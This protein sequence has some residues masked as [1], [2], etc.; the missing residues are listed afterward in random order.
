MANNDTR[1]TNLTALTDAAAYGVELPG[2]NLPTPGAPGLVHIDDINDNE[3]SRQGDIGHFGATDDLTPTL[4]GTL[5]GG[6]GLE[7]RIYA[8]TGFLGTT[9]IDENGNWSFTPDMLEGGSKYTFEVLLKDPL[10]DNILVSQPYTVITTATNGDNGDAASIPEVAG[11]L[12]NVG[13]EQG[14]VF[15]GDTTDDSQPTVFGK[16]DAG[17]VVVI[18]DDGQVIGSTTASDKGNWVFTPET[19]LADG[20]HSITAA[21]VGADG[22]P[23]AQS[24]A[25]DFTVDTAGSADTTPPAAATDLVL[26]D[27]VGPQQGD[28]HNG[29]T[30][31]DAKPTLSGQAEAGATVVVSD[32]GQ[33][34]GSAV[35]GSDGKWS[36]TPETDLKDGS[37]S[38]TTVVEDAAGNKSP[39]SDAI[40]FTVDTG[41]EKPVI[42]SAYDDAGVSTGDVLNHGT[43]DDTTPLLKGTAEAGSIVHISAGGNVAGGDIGS[44]VTDATGHWTFQVP[45]EYALPAANNSNETPIYAVAEDAA[46]N[47][48]PSD[49]FYLNVVPL[50]NGA[51]TTPPAAATDLVLTDDVGP[52]QGDIHNGDTTDDAKPTLSGQAEAGATVVVS[53]GGQLIGSAVAGSDGKWN[54]TPETDLKDGSHSFTTVVEDAAGNKSPASDAIGFT[55]DTGIEKPVITSAYDDAGVNTGDVLN[56]GTT[57]D[58]TPLLKG[59]AEAGSI[60]SIFVGGNIAG[61]AIGSALTDATGHWTFQVPDD[62]ALP[63]VNNSNETPIFAV[64]EDA[65]GNAAVSDS[66]NLNVVASDG[67]STSGLTTVTVSD[68]LQFYIDDDSKLKT[69]DGDG[70]TITTN[71]QQ[72]TNHPA[73]GS[74][75]S[76]LNIQNSF[77]DQTTYMQLDFEQSAKDVHFRLSGLE[78]NAGGARIVITDSEGNVIYDQSEKADGDSSV[79][80]G[81]YSSF[82]FIAPEG[83]TIGN[84]RI[85]GDNTDG[86]KINNKNGI[87]GL[88]I[89]QLQY[90][91]DR[92]YNAETDPASHH[93]H[94]V[95]EALLYN[96][97]NNSYSGEN[98]T[99]T[100]NTTMKQ[101]GPDSTSFDGVRIANSSSVD[102][103]FLLNFEKAA[104]DVNFRISGLENGD[105]GSRVVIKD[106]QGNVLF[107]EKVR[108]EGDTSIKG[109]HYDDFSFTAPQG[110]EIAS[111][112]VYADHALN[113]LILDG[114]HFTYADDPVS[115]QSISLLNSTDVDN[116]LPVP[117][118]SNDAALLTV[119]TLQHAVQNSTVELHDGKAQT[120]SLTAD[121]ILSHGQTDMFIQDG[122]Q[123]LAVQGEEGD[124]VELKL[125]DVQSQWHDAGQSTVAGVTYEVYQH[126]DSNAE[127]LVQQGVELHQS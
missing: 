47:L 65:S 40:D 23:G 88:V 24:P 107:D 110:H 126:G 46:G 119:D 36:F 29:D 55:V 49:G 84:V 81:H 34:I 32:G 69:Y 33:L 117:A 98:F 75:F 86:D 85:Y 83:T 53:D 12:D 127:L 62:H 122:K 7:L 27:D 77:T 113:G 37:H 2:D 72:F 64:A 66:F 26:T 74:S 76:G 14:P 115:H 103:Y 106:T 5:E 78:N 99:I 89:D 10:S 42:T 102:N 68:T 28:I 124:K 93:V 20:E 125:D 41:I 101:S 21:E 63:A 9:V 70:F 58:T 123:Q 1:N 50:D 71:T 48:A 57:D 31:D 82:D 73:D 22:T 94:R 52:Q 90:E 8:N 112:Q 19:P 96:T 109:G 91:Y 87:G 114:L 118:E 80:K 16:A 3:G 35:A 45:D 116:S 17:S 120:L 30:T 51:D 61:E 4:Q 11:I 108:A 59:T 43:T 105:G 54:F 111:V 38:F 6:E 67:G 121:D 79:I 104:T 39:A 56:H 97:T 44:T 13:K 92:P 100:S 15:S 25:T 60:V 18:Y 95:N